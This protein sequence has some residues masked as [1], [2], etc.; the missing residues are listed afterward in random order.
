MSFEV[1]CELNF[2][3]SSPKSTSRDLP[4]PQLKSK[5]KKLLKGMITPDKGNKHSMTSSN[6]I[7]QTVLT[8][9]LLPCCD[10]NLTTDCPDVQKLENLKFTWV[11]C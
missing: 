9:K 6:F 11:K 2:K 5:N 10:S 1:I 7:Q 8:L 4:P 3:G